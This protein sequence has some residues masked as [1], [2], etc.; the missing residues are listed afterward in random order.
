VEGA[1]QDRNREERRK[2]IEPEGSAGQ[3]QDNADQRSEAEEES[4]K[5][6]IGEVR[7]RLGHR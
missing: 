6:S 4:C 7:A 1:D 3:Q 5:V 2:V